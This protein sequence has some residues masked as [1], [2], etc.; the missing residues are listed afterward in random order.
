MRNLLSPEGP[1]MSFLTKITYSA[2]LNILWFICCLP[3]GCFHHCAFLCDIKGSEE[4]RGPPDPGL[5]S[6][7]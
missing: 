2:Y 4:R 3:I 5:L 1:L 7:I 6:L